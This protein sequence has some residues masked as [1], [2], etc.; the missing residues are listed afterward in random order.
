MIDN[1]ASAQDNLSFWEE[2]AVKFKGDVGAV[3]FDNQEEVLEFHFL[4]DLLGSDKKICDLGCGNGRTIFS[5]IDQGVNA[6]FHGVDMTKGMIDAA[7]SKVEELNIRDAFFYNMSATSGNLPSVLGG[8]FD[9]VLTKRLLIN[10]KGSEKYKVIDN[11]YD[12]LEDDGRYIMIESF[13]EPLNKINKIREKLNLAKINVHLFNE[14]LNDGFL[15]KIK[16]KFEIEKIIDFESL[17]YFISRVFNAALSDSKP[18]YDAKINKLAVELTKNFD[19]NIS[20]YSPQI[21][22]ILKKVV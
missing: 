5:M 22:Y 4:K 10:I 2:Q 13:I 20:G 8:E 15:D 17:Y 9:F 19:I 21:M 1:T 3:N 14:Y 18:S 6:M 7:N 11:I 12:L 16:G